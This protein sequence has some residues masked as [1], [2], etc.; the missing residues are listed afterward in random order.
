MEHAVTTC[1]VVQITLFVF[2]AANQELYK[3]S[4]GSVLMI[5]GAK[6]TESIFCLCLIISRASGKMWAVCWPE[7]LSFVSVAGLLLWCVVLIGLCKVSI[8]MQAQGAATIL[9]PGNCRVL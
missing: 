9:F 8:S 3:E 7:P 5:S 6:V 1:C 2:G 4:E